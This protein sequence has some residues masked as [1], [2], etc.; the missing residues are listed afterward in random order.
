MPKLVSELS[1]TPC[2]RR[3]SAELAHPSNSSQVSSQTIAVSQVD[4]SADLPFAI[5]VVIAESMIVTEVGVLVKYVHQF[6]KSWHDTNP[7]N[8]TMNKRTI[9]G[10]VIG[11]GLLVAAAWSFGWIEGKDPVV[12]ELEQMRDESVAR[13]D[14]M[15]DAEKKASRKEM[16]ERVRELPEE[17]RRKFFES[18]M[19]IFMKMAE[20]RLDTFLEMTPEEQRAELD[21]KID[22]MLSRQENSSERGERDKKWRGKSDKEVDAW[23]KK[24]LDWTTPEQRA[25]F[26][27]AVQKYRD[28]LEERGIDDPKGG[29]FF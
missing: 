10:G 2:T 8:R 26:E 1:A 18:S 9:V 20:A 11:V 3:D 17:Q 29:R 5:A 14:Q 23:R 16:G 4:F 24:M 12:A 19:P 28:R 15:T 6:R 13:H 7:R 22:R 21:K 27:I 25:K